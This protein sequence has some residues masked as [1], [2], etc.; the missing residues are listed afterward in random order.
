MRGDTEQH[1][2]GDRCGDVSRH[3]A[4]IVQCEQRK[5]DRTS[6]RELND[7]TYATLNRTKPFLRF[8]EATGT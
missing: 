8:A 5:D 4:Q 6:P 2:Q 1:S 7:P 3:R